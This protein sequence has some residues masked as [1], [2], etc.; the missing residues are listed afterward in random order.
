MAGQRLIVTGVEDA[1][2]ASFA[3][4]SFKD[5]CPPTGSVGVGYPVM[6]TAGGPC[7]FDLVR[8][9]ARTRWSLSICSV[10]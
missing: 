3:F 7:P 1:D 9:P 5:C 6:R 8:L 2:G 10:V 4:F